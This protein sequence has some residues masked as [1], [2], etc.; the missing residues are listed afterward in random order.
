MEPPEYLE[1]NVKAEQ[2]EAER[3]CYTCPQRPLRRSQRPILWG[4][5]LPTRSFLSLTLAGAT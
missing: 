5:G 4:Y 3:D 2:Q 1:S